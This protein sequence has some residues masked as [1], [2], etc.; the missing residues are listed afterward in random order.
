MGRL[1]LQGV[2]KSFHGQPVVQDIDL[3]V[4]DGEFVVIVGP[5]GSG[6]STLLRMIAGL[7][8]ITTGEMYLD[9]RLINDTL[10]QERSIGMV[11]QSYA[12]Y[13]H[14][15]VA[16]NMSYG[17]TLAKRPKEEVARR[18]SE[19]AQML[20]L[21][22]LL[23]RKPAA[24]SGGQRQRVA[25]GRALIK[26]PA[27]FLF[28]EPLSNLDAALRVEMRVQIAHLHQKLRA[29][30]I[31]VT[32]DQV[33]A[34]TLADRIV[35][36]SSGNIAQVGTPL[37]LYHFPGTL[38][39]ATFIGSPRMNILSVVIEEGLSSAMRVRLPG[40]ALL[41]VAVDG[42]RA[43]PGETALLGVRPE[44]FQLAEDA[45]ARLP[46]TLVLRENLGHE[47]LAY[48]QVA[49]VAQSLTQRLPGTIELTPGSSA[50][51]GLSGLRCHL[52]S[53]SGLAYP[54]LAVNNR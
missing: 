45:D 35:M 50:E 10:P 24:L 48:Y 44:D 49:G 1:V 33:E 2:G 11:F 6:K 17:L 29:T 40:G 30:M 46:A 27:L 41:T 23:S 12:L 32:H 8:D 34:M 20:Q 25:I 28:D 7:E 51:L 16:E 13:P 22:P 39:V 36:M 53:A 15:T 21:T 38:E 52:F 3:A 42:S 5:S 43:Q 4:K 31:Y 47:T 37:E 9:G 14:M 18:V 19:A 54:R 26:E